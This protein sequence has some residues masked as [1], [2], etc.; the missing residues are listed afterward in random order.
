MSV[1][2]T[3]F[4]TLLHDNGSR[5]TDATVFS[6]KNGWHDTNE[7][8]RNEKSKEKLN[9]NFMIQSSNGSYVQLLRSN[10]SARSE[11]GTPTKHTATYTRNGILLEIAR[12][13]WVNDVVGM[14]VAC[15][16]S[17]LGICVSACDFMCMDGLKREREREWKSA[18]KN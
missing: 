7:S 11:T 2:L 14:C 18:R 15:T 5:A 12:L 6:T 17:T 16:Y 13:I 10:T 1:K 8:E 3:L 9:K 4:L